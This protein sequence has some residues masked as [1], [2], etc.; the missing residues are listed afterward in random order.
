MRRRQRRWPPIWRRNRDCRFP[1]VAAGCFPCRIYRGN[2]Q[3]EIPPVLLLSGLEYLAMANLSFDIRTY[4]TPAASPVPFRLD[5]YRGVAFIGSFVRKN[6]DLHRRYRTMRAKLQAPR[7]T[8]RRIVAELQRLHPVGGST[9]R[10]KIAVRA[11]SW[12]A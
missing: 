2:F 3:E 8:L 9:N 12:A 5:P 1:C 7:Q 10:M 4:L 11:R 6:I